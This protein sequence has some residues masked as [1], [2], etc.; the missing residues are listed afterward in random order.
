MGPQK[1]G[2]SMH[3][4]L[5]TAA[6]DWVLTCH[7]DHDALPVWQAATCTQCAWLTG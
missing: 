3:S 2:H 6:S 1:E 5:Q 7:T 4:G